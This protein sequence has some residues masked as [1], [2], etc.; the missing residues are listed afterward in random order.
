MAAGWL[1][2]RAGADWSEALLTVTGR[3]VLGLPLRLPRSFRAALILGLEGLLRVQLTRD[4][5]LT[6]PRVPTMCL[7]ED[8]DFWLQIDRVRAAVSF[9]DLGIQPAA[10]DYEDVGLALTAVSGWMAQRGFPVELE[11]RRGY[12]LVFDGE[13]EG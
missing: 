8:S 5:V 10:L 3:V 7:D 13:P 1:R 6:G 12:V 11:A 9:D 4:A 2:R